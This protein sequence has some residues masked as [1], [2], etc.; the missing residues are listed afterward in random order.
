MYHPDERKATRF[1]GLM[2]C[3]EVMAPRY[4]LRSSGQASKRNGA[5]VDSL[6]KNKAL[7]VLAD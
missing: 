5:K 1:F 3:G 4:P 6:P 2:A 7:R